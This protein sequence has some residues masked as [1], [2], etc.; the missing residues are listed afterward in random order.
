MQLMGEK[1]RQKTAIV[2]GML[3]SLLITMKGEC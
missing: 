3:L 1:A 2:I